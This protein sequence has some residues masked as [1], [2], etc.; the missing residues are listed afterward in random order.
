VVLAR[1]ASARDP[2][3]DLSLVLICTLASV[4]DGDNRSVACTPATSGSHVA[5]G[6]GVAGG[7]VGGR[8]LD[9]VSAASSVPRST[10]AACR[11]ACAWPAPSP[12]RGLSSV[13]TTHL[14]W[15]PG[16]AA[17]TTAARTRMSARA[18]ATSAP[19]RAFIQPQCS[20]RWSS[21]CKLSDVQA[22]RVQLRIRART[23]YAWC[24]NAVQDLCTMVLA[25]LTVSQCG[26][27]MQLVA[28][29]GG[30]RV[31][32]Y[33]PPGP[34]TGAMVSE[35]WRGNSVRTRAHVG[36]WQSD[37]PAA[38]TAPKVVL[39]SQ[40]AAFISL[41]W[42]VV[43]VAA[44]AVD[45]QPLPVS[46]IAAAG[47]IWNANP[48]AEFA[49]FRRAFELPCCV[50]SAALRVTAQV[51]MHILACSLTAWYSSHYCTHSMPP[52]ELTVS[53][54]A[55]RSSHCRHSTHARTCP[56]PQPHDTRS[57]SQTHMRDSYSC[58]CPS[59]LHRSSS[60]P[61]PPRPPCC[62]PRPRLLQH[63]TRPMQE[64]CQSF[65]AH[66]EWPSTGYFWQL[67][68]GATE[69]ASNRWTSSTSLP[70]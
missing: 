70:F 56:R 23:S 29:V 43:V 62:A 35:R 14:D 40:W 33:R 45:T 7:M 11:R 18:G 38:H 36:C 59:S 3:S 8:V 6:S 58:P 31:R 42:L 41:H 51:P 44:T 30:K 47:P 46:P 27:D 37:R 39:L 53:D 26:I 54:A 61:S 66:T 52:C 16:C 17:A 28:P 24:K 10:P 67:A 22:V 49:L 5:G 60:P 69:K 1:V 57:Q 34:S 9:E 50:S 68:P 32:V 4:I 63:G 2:L 20:R 55:L 48:N 21:S 15:A 64:T 12:V 13:S 19:I 25:R 65:S